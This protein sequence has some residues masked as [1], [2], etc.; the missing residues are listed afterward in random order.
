MTT[1]NALVTLPF[2]VLEPG[3]ATIL[4]QYDEDGDGWQSE[5]GGI[6]PQLLTLKLRNDKSAVID[7]IEI[8]CH[9]SKVPNKVGIDLGISSNAISFSACETISHL[10][11]IVFNE[12]DGKSRELK[13]IPI[14]RKANYVRLTLHGSHEG[15]QN[16]HKQ[17]GIAAIRVLSQGQET[18]G[19]VPIGVDIDMPN[20]RV[21]S[22]ASNS[23][24]L[25]IKNELDPKISASVE[26]LERLKKESAAVEDFDTAA[27]IKQE[28]SKVYALLIAF[29]ESENLMKQAARDE[30]YVEASRLKAER[31]ERKNAARAALTEVEQQFAVNV[32]AENAAN[33][34]ISTIKSFTSERSLRDQKNDEDNSFHSDEEESTDSS[35]GRDNSSTDNSSSPRSGRSADDHPLAGVYG[36]EELP[37][38]EDIE[39]DISTDLVHKVE[40]LFGSYRAKCF[41]SKNWALREAAL[42]KMTLMVPEICSSGSADVSE[43]FSICES[44]IIEDKN[45]Q[46]NLSG[47]ILLDEALLQLETTSKAPISM[48]PQLSRILVDLFAKMADNSKKV[49][50]SAEISLLA[51][52]HSS[53]VDVS[54]VSLLATKRVRSKEAKGGRTVRA[55]LQFLED[56]SAEFGVDVAWKKII[57]FAKSA[58]AF[59]HR[60]GSVRDAA[61]S[62]VMTLATIH[63]NEVFKSLE[64]DLAERQL[65]ELQLGFQLVQ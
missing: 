24:P 19:D 29:K 32:N 1:D 8:L 16:P 47:L 52:A 3:Q 34:S 5:E 22:A 60:D 39:R 43:I 56:L 35:A 49:A 40:S 15:P 48:T 6:Y 14:G 23:L 13:T 65:R 55:R 37:S 28:L 33:L 57:D 61:K 41:F 36:A 12:S 18:K 42:A 27:R 38:P 25:R 58:K 2:S 26:R 17:V 21:Q 51:L 53:S 54:Y 4:E 9:E 59:D 20:K 50:D 63:G 62:L 64:G 10:G 46:V 11:Y 45:V 44:S 30:D 7:V 31:D